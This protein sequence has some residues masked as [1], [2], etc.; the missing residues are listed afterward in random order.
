[1]A[2][3][4]NKK[5]AKIGEVELAVDFKFSAVESMEAESLKRHLQLNTRR[6]KR[7]EDMRVEIYAYFVWCTSKIMKPRTRG[8]ASKADSDNESR[9]VDSP[10]KGTDKG[11]GKGK[12]KG[13][14]KLR[15]C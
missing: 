13:Y 6:L 12:G 4:Y 2:A 5:N 15:R 1:M 7:Y 9:D 14:G 8:V 10:S 11:Q 3:Q